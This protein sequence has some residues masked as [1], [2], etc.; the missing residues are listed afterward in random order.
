V[1]NLVTLL[2]IG[3]IAA[4][5]IFCVAAESAQG[6]HQCQ[7]DTTCDDHGVP[8]PSPCSD[9][10]GSCICSGAI[11][12]VDVRPP[13]PDSSLSPLPVFALPALAL[14]HP[15]FLHL[16]RDGAPTGLIAFGD[17]GTVRAFLQVYR[18]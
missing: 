9:D 16:T 4:C 17:A 12:A 11:Q 5:P 8:S 13:G 3:L 1:R 15:L 6:L 18:C 14:P 7:A 2:L 10:G